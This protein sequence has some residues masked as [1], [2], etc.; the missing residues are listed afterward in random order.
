[1]CTVALAFG[2]TLSWNRVAERLEALSADL[3][4]A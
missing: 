2:P 1:M 3:A 4:R